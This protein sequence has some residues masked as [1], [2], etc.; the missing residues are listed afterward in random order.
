MRLIH[1]A[2]WH[3]GDQLGRV[4]RT[5]DLRRRVEIVADLCEKHSADVLLIAGDLFSEQAR[6]EQMTDDLRHLLS[7]FADFFARGGTILA[8]TGNHD[9]DGKINLIRTGMAMAA[10]AP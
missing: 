8:L 3:L 10:P 7:V 4:D 9:I 5:D 1:T 6:I 2:D